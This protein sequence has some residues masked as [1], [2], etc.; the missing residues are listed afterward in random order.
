MWQTVHPTFLAHLTDHP[1]ILARKLTVAIRLGSFSYIFSDLA[2]DFYMVFFHD[3]SGDHSASLFWAYIQSINVAL[4]VI[5][6]GQLI[7]I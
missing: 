3:Q 4:H 5:N 1:E 7:S 2:W 6:Y